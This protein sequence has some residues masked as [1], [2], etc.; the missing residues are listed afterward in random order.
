MKG[1]KK[2]SKALVVKADEFKPEMKWIPPG[3][4]KEDFEV[5]EVHIFLKRKKKQ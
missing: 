3:A 1:K 5:S 2:Q 4:S